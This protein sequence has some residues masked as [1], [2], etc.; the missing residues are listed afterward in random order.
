MRNIVSGWERFSFWRYMINPLDLRV[1]PIKVYKKVIKLSFKQQKNKIW[2]LVFSFMYLVSV[3]FENL[4]MTKQR[5]SIEKIT[6]FLIKPYKVYENRV[7][8]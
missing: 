7:V 6:P 3:F 1:A 2:G 5:L 4:Q 8:G